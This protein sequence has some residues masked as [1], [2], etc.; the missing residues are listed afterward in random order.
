MHIARAGKKCGLC[1]NDVGYFGALNDGFRDPLISMCRA[2]YGS[3]DLIVDYSS[4]RIRHAIS[5]SDFGPKMPNLIFNH[6]VWVEEVQRLVEQAHGTSF[7]VIERSNLCARCLNVY[8]T[9][10]MRE[11]PREPFV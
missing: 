1:G 6:L 8:R 10:S 11:L 5:K 9:H 2:C 4:W 7:E 3:N